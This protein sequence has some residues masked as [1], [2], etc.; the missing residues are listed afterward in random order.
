M[1]LGITIVACSDLILEIGHSF[2]H[3]PDYLSGK[4]KVH[5]H[6][7]G[8]RVVVHGH[9]ILNKLEKAANKVNENDSNDRRHNMQLL[10]F[11]Q[12]K[13]FESTL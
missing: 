12:L 8:D 2:I 11:D 5:S 4:M 10:T 3:T 9:E 6:K 1:A 7:V 13:L